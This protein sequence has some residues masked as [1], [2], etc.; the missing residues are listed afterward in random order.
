MD[1]FVKKTKKKKDHSEN[2]RKKIVFLPFGLRNILEKSDLS[3]YI[4]NVHLFFVDFALR[5]PEIDIVIK[6]KPKQPGA[7]RKT[8]LLEPLKDSSIEIEKIPNL[9]IREDLDL[10]DLIL[11]TDVVCGLQTSALI[12][13]AVVGLPVTIPYFKDLQNP[14]YDERLYY[15][16]MYDLFDIANNVKELEILLLERLH[17]P[18]ID[19]KVMRRREVLFEDYISS[20]DCNATEKYVECIKQ[21]IENQIV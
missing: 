8:V 21:I 14:K 7:P 19:K 5:H 17:N 16:D 12:E 2:M 9:T 20:L 4:C 10:H 15:R 3:S 1:S 13:A 18:V 6:S 11:E